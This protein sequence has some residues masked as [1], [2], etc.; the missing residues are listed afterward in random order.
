M[1]LGDKTVEFVMCFHDTRDLVLWFDSETSLSCS[2][3]LT[4]EN[5]LFTKKCH[6]YSP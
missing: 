4:V 2:P 6:L 1:T 5:F 3:K